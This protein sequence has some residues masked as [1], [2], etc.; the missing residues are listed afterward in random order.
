MKISLDWLAEYVTWDDE[1]AELAAKLTSAG[2]NVEAIEKFETTFPGVVVARVLE[3]EQ[4]PN[5]DRL[6]LCKVDDGS[7][8]PVQ[9]V[10]GAPNV[11]EGLTVLF[12]RVGAV[13]P[14]DFKLKKTKIRGL[15]SLGMICSATE[16]ELG[17]DGS[18]IVELDT[19]L[20]P[21][22]PADE[23]YGYSDSVLDIEVTPNRPDWLSHV[24]VAREVAAIYGVKVSMPPVWNSQ[25]SGESLGMKVK[26]DDYA[27]CPRYMAFGAVDV[28]LGPSPDWMQNRL[29]AVGS[30]PI[31]NV[32]DI[33]NYVM[34]ELGQPMH[35]F[36]RAKLSGGTITVKRSGA[37]AKLVTLDEQEREIDPDT[38]LIC[39]E[40]GPVG[41]AG[42]MGLAN[43]EVGE[44]TTEILL[45]SAYFAPGLVRAT[46]RGMGLIS[47]ASYRFERGADW[48]MVE[49][50]AHRGLHLF[51]DL[52]GAHIVPDW[53]D[54]Y[55]PDRRPPEAVPL[56]IWQVNRLLGS[57]IGTDEAAQMLQSLGLKVQPMGN[58]ASSTPNAVNMMVEVPT[59]RRDVHHEVDLIEEL[60]R[61]HGFDQ[62]AV[63][64]GFRAT[65][66]GLRD[67]RETVLGKIRAWV[68]AIGHHEMVTSSFQAAGDAD[69]LG[70]AED[71]PRRPALSVINPR[72]GGDTTLRTCLLPSLLEVVRRNLNSGAETPLR[73]FQIAR[74]FRPAGAKRQDPQREDDLLLPEE[75]LFLQIGVAG[76][77]GEGR[78][79]VP[80]D[81]LELKGTIEGLARHLRLGITLDVGGEEIWL[82]P[83][84]QWRVL[85]GNGTVVGTAGRVAPAVAGAFDVDKAIAVAEIR[86]DGLDLTPKPMRFNAFG[87]YP[88]VKRDLSLLVPDQVAYGQVETVVRKNS[89]PYLES[90]ELFD[91]Y[92]GKGIP[93]GHG[94]LGIRLKFRSD[95]GNLKGKSVDGAIARL[96][97]ALVDELGIE[98]RAQD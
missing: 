43:S 10:C 23:L 14:G 82:Q 50:A 63:E 39:D 95:K 48:D 56:R 51:Q 22:T 1:P 47:D 66:E 53:A 33:A 78:G 61:A 38:L 57:E 64:G 75:P 25:Q 72:H 83:G 28:K 46:S 70:L 68:A 35:A 3:R 96:V 60:A 45:E 6:S 7:G 4:H 42:V 91:I 8:A 32:V 19:D 62:M 11:R 31:N 81:M 88:A 93:E 71:D 73:L 98:H 87:R 49:R 29:R 92:R 17:S 89:G 36:D 58:P 21:G 9:V 13:L 26:I 52:T 54:R 74:T 40:R 80:Q 79:G 90:V 27:D 55:D 76:H 67:P 20:P 41:L 69:A 84:G 85:D 30:R 44:E 15:E 12:A 37:A 77:G 34:L 18:G 59:F 65:G 5:A 94:A 97:T 24:G 16:L 86:L 2:L